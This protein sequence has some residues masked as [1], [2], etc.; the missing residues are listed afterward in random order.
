MLNRLRQQLKDHG[1]SS[2]VLG[3]WRQGIGKSGPPYK[4]ARVSMLN[5]SQNIFGGWNRAIYA[6][7]S[8]EHCSAFRR[9]PKAAVI[10]LTLFHP[11]AARSPLKWDLPGIYFRE[12]SKSH[13]IYFRY[14]TCLRG[15]EP[16]CITFPIIQRAQADCFA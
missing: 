15:T 13:G 9:P 12:A 6:H 3:D 14:S 4:I 8:R 16:Y 11:K 2:G 5:V 7:P 1:Q 10:C